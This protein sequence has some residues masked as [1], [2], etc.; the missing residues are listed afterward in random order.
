V[1]TDD[2]ELSLRRVQTSELR[3]LGERPARGRVVLS[4]A[5]V[6]NLMDRAD[7]WPGPGRLHMGGFAYENLVPRGPFPLRMRLRWVAAASAE[8][9]PEPYERLAA[10]LREGGEDE[11]A[12]EVLLAKQRRRRESQPVAAKLWGYAQDWTVAYG[13]RPGR[14]HGRAL[15]GRGPGLRPRPPP[16]DQERGAPG[17]EPVAVRPRPAA[18]GH[19]P[20]AGRVLAAAGRLAVAGGGVHPAGLDPGHHGRGG[21][22]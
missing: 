9:N 19:R 15:G 22:H 12:R 20:G 5:R 10:V 1:L 18:A 4:G 6:V 16:A 7:S 8:Y 13:Y 14:G 3:F 21:R 2:Q 11:D 17:L